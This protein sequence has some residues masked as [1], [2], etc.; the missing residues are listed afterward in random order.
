MR[1]AQEMEV[2]ANTHFHLVQ[3]VCTVQLEESK[4]VPIFKG[5][6]KKAQ[7]PP[8]SDTICIQGISMNF[9]RSAKNVILRT[10]SEK[11]FIWIFIVKHTGDNPQ[12]TTELS[13]L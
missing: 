1:V 5:E 12:R 4:A 2:S 3:D 6:I 7:A 8:E 11:L 9:Q 10:S 13:E